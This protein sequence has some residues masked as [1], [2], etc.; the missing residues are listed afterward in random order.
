METFQIVTPDMIIL[1]NLKIMN[2]GNFKFRTFWVLQMIE[3]PSIKSNH[4]RGTQPW[5]KIK[6]THKHSGPLVA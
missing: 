5:I 2:H 4:D 6:A 3:T 1:Y